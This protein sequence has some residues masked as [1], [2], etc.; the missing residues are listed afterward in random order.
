MAYW[1]TSALVKL[2]IQEPDSAVFAARI[3]PLFTVVSSLLARL[4]FRATMRRNES[5]GSLTRPEAIRAISKLD[6]DLA[7]GRLTLISV[8]P[9]VVN[10]FE[11]VVDQCYGMSPPI[12]LRTLDAI[13]LA[14]ALTAGETEL[15][16]T[17]LRLR[18]AAISVG[19][20]VFPSP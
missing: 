18:K 7:A 10:E 19:L 11:R 9:S 17:D 6:V 8:E 14:S 12:P 3:R 20:T 15:V 13:H 4:E 2:Y 16:T 1:D 5:L